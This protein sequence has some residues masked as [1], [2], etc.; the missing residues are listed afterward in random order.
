M[1]LRL[2]SQCGA[3]AAFSLCNLIS[4]VAV[5]PRRQKCGIASLYCSGCIQR[6]TEL[7]EACGHSSLENLGQSLN[8]AYTALAIAAAVPSDSRIERK[9]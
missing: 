8:E 7:L 5:S 9:S 4:T 3:P 6:L 2:C 1:S